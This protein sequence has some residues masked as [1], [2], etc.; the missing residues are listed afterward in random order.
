MLSSPTPPT[1][2]IHPTHFIYFEPCE[3]FFVSSPGFQAYALALLSPATHLAG[4]VIWHTWII[5]ASFAN[6]KGEIWKSFEGFP[7]LPYCSS[8]DIRQEST[9]FETSHEERTVS[10][11]KGWIFR[12]RSTDLGVQSERE[13]GNQELYSPALTVVAKEPKRE[14]EQLGKKR[15]RWLRLNISKAFLI[16]KSW[17]WHALPGEVAESYLK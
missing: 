4:S 12:G 3:Q 15:N 2:V 7:T 16:G 13:E 5:C 8:K 1:I 9:C 6:R 14:K 17:N 10:W 11:E